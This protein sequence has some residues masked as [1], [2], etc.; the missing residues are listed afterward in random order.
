MST[1]KTLNYRWTLNSGGISI[2][3]LSYQRRCGHV[4]GRVR[5]VAYMLYATCNQAKHNCLVT[6]IR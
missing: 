2:T 3:S 5:G 6:R 4:C 1:L